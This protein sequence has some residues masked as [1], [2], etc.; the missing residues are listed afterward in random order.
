M[1]IF[2]QSSLIENNTMRH[3]LI[4]DVLENLLLVEK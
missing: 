2:Y 3:Y 4:F 1:F